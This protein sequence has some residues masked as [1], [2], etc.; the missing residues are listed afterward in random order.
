MVTWS[1]FSSGA[2]EKRDFEKGSFWKMMYGQ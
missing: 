2:S 1:Y